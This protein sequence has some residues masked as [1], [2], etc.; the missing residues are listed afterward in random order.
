MKENKNRDDKSENDSYRERKPAASPDSPASYYR[1]RKKTPS[2][3]VKTRY[4][5]IYF[6][7]IS[8]RQLE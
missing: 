1:D 8:D 3:P 7:S 4:R 2:P 5:Y 6:F